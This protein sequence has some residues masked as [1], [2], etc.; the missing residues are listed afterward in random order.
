LEFRPAQNI[1]KLEKFKLS[2]ADKSAHNRTFIAKKSD[3]DNNW[4][5]LKAIILDLKAQAFD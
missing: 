5:T 2:V 1:S 4:E 3:I